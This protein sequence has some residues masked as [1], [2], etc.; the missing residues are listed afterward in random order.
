M[1][2]EHVSLA[3][4]RELECGQDRATRIECVQQQ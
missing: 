3:I 2:D 1:P 4:D